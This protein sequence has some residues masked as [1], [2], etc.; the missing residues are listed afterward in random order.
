MS[1]KTSKGVV[2]CAQNVEADKGRVLNYIGAAEQT[3]RGVRKFLNLP[4][5]LLTTDPTANGNFDNIVVVPKR[6]TSHRAMVTSNDTITYNWDNDHRID[7]FEY[8]PYERTIMIDADYFVMGDRLQ[9]WPHLMG[10]FMIMPRAHDVTGRNMYGN[11]QYLGDQ[12]IPM[13]WATVM[14]WD[15]EAKPFFDAAKMVRENYEMYALMTGMPVIPFRNDVAFSIAEHLLNYKIG[16]VGGLNTLPADASAV[17]YSKGHKALVFEYVRD[18]GKLTMM[19]WKEKDIHYI[20]KD[21]LYKPATLALIKE[22][23]DN[24]GA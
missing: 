15:E 14:A 12:S 23:Y 20:N 5:T 8:S 19:M 10:V 6:A 7:A 3:A 18:D 4:V 17:A 1:Q 2:I 24:A 22:Y 11:S 9:L 21:V 16:D 13:R